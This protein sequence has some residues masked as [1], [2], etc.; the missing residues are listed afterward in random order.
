MA[1]SGEKSYYNKKAAIT[2]RFTARIG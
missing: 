2:P 1:F